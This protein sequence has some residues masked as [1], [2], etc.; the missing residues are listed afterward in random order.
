MCIL[1]FAYIYNGDIIRYI[2][3]HEWRYMYEYIEIVY[4]VL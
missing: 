2:Q 3:G 4:Q 1:Y